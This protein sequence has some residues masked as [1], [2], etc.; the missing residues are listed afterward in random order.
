MNEV[1]C[2]FKNITILSIKKAG[3]LECYNSKSSCLLM[4]QDANVIIRLSI[5]IVFVLTICLKY[6]QIRLWVSMVS[7]YISSNIISKGGG[8]S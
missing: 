3:G 1:Q 4:I 6:V 7:T 2:Y 5:Y 8:I